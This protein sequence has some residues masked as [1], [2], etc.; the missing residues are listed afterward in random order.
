MQEVAG[1]SDQVGGHPSL[2]CL[3]RL[4]L[5]V[6]MEG[7]LVSGRC[8]LSSVSLAWAP[9]HLLCQVKSAL[10]LPP[11]LAKFTHI[12]ALEHPQYPVGTFIV[13]SKTNSIGMCVMCVLWR[14]ASCDGL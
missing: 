5:A 12:C 7:Y 14:W 4:T 13:S 2:P 3:L 8:D 1:K 6:R 11:T 10:S 9:P